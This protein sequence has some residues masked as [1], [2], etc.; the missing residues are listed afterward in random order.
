MDVL[1]DVVVQLSMKV[2][3][4]AMLPEGL[5][6]MYKYETSAYKVQYYCRSL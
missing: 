4:D 1:C 5:S 6:L 2:L 3:G